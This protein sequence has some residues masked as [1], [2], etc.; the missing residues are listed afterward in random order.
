MRSIDCKSRAIEE[1]GKAEEFTKIQ[2]WGPSEIEAFLKGH[3]ISLSSLPL[4][5]LER[6][7]AKEPLKALLP[8]IARYFYWRN[9]AQTHLNTHLTNLYNTAEDP[10]FRFHGQKMG[11]R[12]LENQALPAVLQAAFILQIISQPTLQIELDQMGV[13]QIKSFAKRSMG[14]MLDGTNADNY[15]LFHD[16]ARKPLV[17]QELQSMLGKLDIDQ[18]RQKLFPTT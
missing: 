11:W 6:I 15:F 2:N 16:P 18:V 10:D 1:Q 17:L 12:I 4:A 7:N 13:C 3:N 5:S 9:Q 14:W 8:A